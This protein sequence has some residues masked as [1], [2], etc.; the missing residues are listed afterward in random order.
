MNGLKKFM[1]VMLLSATVLCPRLSSAMEIQ[2]F[3]D[4]ANQDQR[5]YLKF[6][7]KGAQKVL[8]EQG[9]R[10]LATKVDQLFHKIHPGDHQSLGEAKFEENLAF[11]RVFI[12]ENPNGP[13]VPRS[14]LC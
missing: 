10:D 4:M 8:I 6:L 14:N 11:N 2:M 1:L 13:C 7:V 12:A 9:R 3:N 5:D